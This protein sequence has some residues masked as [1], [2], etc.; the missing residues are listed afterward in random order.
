MCVSLSSAI[1]FLG[2][3]YLGPG[4]RVAERL[5]AGIKP[6]NGLDKAALDHDLFYSRFDDLPNRHI[7]DA[8]LEKK[9]LK[10]VLSRDAS[11]SERTVSL[12]TAGVMR[13][14]RKLGLGLKSLGGR[15]KKRKSGLGM[16]L[17]GG[18]SRKRRTTK[19]K[20]HHKLS[21]GQLVK[22][23]KKSIV[24]KNRSGGDGGGDV[25]EHARITLAAVRR[26]IQRKKGEIFSYL[27]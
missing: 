13:A 6:V 8:I 1:L 12:L 7:A 26:E 5:R 24:G 15:R 22:V 21:F 27:V 10:R 18:E 4:T 11:L 9:A 14:K 17:G 23:A 25:D 2:Y 3:N 19:K 16:N 20:K